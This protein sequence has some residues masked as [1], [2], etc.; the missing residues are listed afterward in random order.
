MDI[1]AW[2]FALKIFSPDFFLTV[3]ARGILV[4]ETIKDYTNNF[5]S[6]AIWK[7]EFCI[8]LWLPGIFFLFWKFNNEFLSF[9]NSVIQQNGSL[10]EQQMCQHGQ[11][12]RVYRGQWNC[13]QSNISREIPELTTSKSINDTGHVPT[14]QRTRVFSRDCFGTNFKKIDWRRRV[15][16]G[17]YSRKSVHECT[18]NRSGDWYSFYNGVGNL[19]SNRIDPYHL[20]PV[21]T[22]L[23]TVETVR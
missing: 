15:N 17:A 12:L 13:Y 14:F 19:N 11:L 18:R 9:S 16:F 6:R 4:K 23:P 10:L 8:F 20:T 2:K 7:K 5:K 21:A 1:T 22:I 3:L